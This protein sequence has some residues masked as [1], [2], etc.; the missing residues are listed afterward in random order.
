MKKYFISFG[1][2]R[3]QKSLNRI[4]FQ[5]E[6]MQ[7]Y[8]EIILYTEKE[9]SKE[10]WEHFKDKTHYR[11]FGYGFWKPQIILQTL[12]KMQDG[13]ILHYADCG[14]HLNLRGRQRLL[15]YFEI[16]NNSDFGILA[17]QAAIECSDKSLKVENW[18]EKEWTKGDL[19]D[20]FGV[21]DRKDISETGQI[22]STTFFCKK[23]NE[24]M[25][26]MRKFLKVYYDD[27]DLLA[28]KV[29][30][31]GNFSEFKENRHDQ[32]IFS[33]LCKINKVFTISNAEIEPCPLLE[34][35]IVLKSYPIWA[36]RDKD[37]E[38]YF[39]LNCLVINYKM[40]C[41]LVRSLNIEK[42][43]SFSKKLIQ[44]IIRMFVKNKRK[45]K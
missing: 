36:L 4:K 31:N 5:A 19:F 11:I 40:K 20:Y 8:D 3:M 37:I 6:L 21:R 28:N 32:A 26:F 34:T 23:S 16:V 22:V 45:L 41:R 15:E 13:D 17:F 38:F 39:P 12:E 24:T 9:L 27:F 18:L 10:V 29:D 35:K 25:D 33:L 43:A 44:R 30:K 14:C 7:V 1:D 2:S 42:G